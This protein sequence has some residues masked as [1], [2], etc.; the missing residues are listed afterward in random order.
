[1]LLSSWNQ[2]VMGS[3][4]RF[5]VGCAYVSL[6]VLFPV[7]WLSA[8]FTNHHMVK[9][10]FFDYS[11]LSLSI[12]SPLQAYRS[13]FRQFSQK[14]L[15]FMCNKWSFNQRTFC[16]TFLPREWDVPLSRIDKL[17]FFQ[18]GLIPL[19][20]IWSMN[21]VGDGIACI[22]GLDVSDSWEII[23][24]WEDFLLNCQ[25]ANGICFLFFKS[26]Y[27]SPCYRLLVWSVFVFH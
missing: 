15:V 21:L 27:S 26:S 8:E 24:R 17:P 25:C 9:G 10:V 2:W 14:V 11:G 13:S 5:Y 4:F 20:R 3:L 6:Y 16:N 23:V 19:N 12:E 7:R 22:H 1:M 18:Q